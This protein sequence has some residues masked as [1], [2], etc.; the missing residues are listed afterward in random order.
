LREIGRAHRRDI[1]I[2][3]ICDEPDAADGFRALVDRSGR[4]AL[5]RR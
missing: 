4:A 3:R 1:R 5:S 2:K